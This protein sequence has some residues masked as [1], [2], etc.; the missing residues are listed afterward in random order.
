MAVQRGLRNRQLDP[1]S[2]TAINAL[3]GQPEI[4][5]ERAASDLEARL[6][7]LAHG[8]DP[9]AIPGVDREARG[10][11]LEWTPLATR[12]LAPDAGHDHVFGQVLAG[13]EGGPAHARHA[14]P[15]R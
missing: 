4:P 5:A 14:E 3:G 9:G 2:I 15:I 7:L 13:I 6:G 1:I 11:P 8:S 10:D 12:L